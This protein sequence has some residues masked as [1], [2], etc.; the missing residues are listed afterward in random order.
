MQPSAAKHTQNVVVSWLRVRNDAD[1]LTGARC[2]NGAAAKEV[3][4]AAGVVGH[5]TRVLARAG[6]VIHRLKENDSSERE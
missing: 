5:E 6:V 3:K 2:R 4:V 1:V